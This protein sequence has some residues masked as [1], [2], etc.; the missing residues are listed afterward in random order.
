MANHRGLLALCVLVCVPPFIQGCATAAT[1]TLDYRPP[2]QSVITNEATVDKRFEAVWSD[3]VR[4]LAKGYF[5]VNNIE[6]ESRLINVSFSTTNPEDYIDCGVSNRVFSQ[7]STIVNTSYNVAGDSSYKYGGGIDS[8]GANAIIHYVDR[9]TSLEGRIN[10]Y[11]APDETMTD[12]SVNVR[13]ILTIRISGRTNAENASGVVM[14]S[15]PIQEPALTPISFN[16]NQPNKDAEGI[17][18]I[19]KGVLENEILTMALSP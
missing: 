1:G 3:L 15:Q 18:C 4:Q 7:G 8:T 11:V 17:S 2:E 13:Y 6:K 10:I 5:V 9:T 16:T 14:R 19:S 12:V